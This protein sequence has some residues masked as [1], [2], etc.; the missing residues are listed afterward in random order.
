LIILTHYSK[1]LSD[2]YK[3]TEMKPKV[4]QIVKWWQLDNFDYDYFLKSDY[5]KYYEKIMNFINW[6]EKIELWELRSFIDKLY[7]P[8]F[9]NIIPEDVII[10]CQWKCNTYNHNT[11][12]D[13]S[14]I[15]NFRNFTKEIFEKLYSFEFITK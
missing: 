13:E 8:I 3:F 14:D 6:W 15:E 12:T 4:Y 11:F 9:C 2:Y 5:L 1:F 7:S 10:D